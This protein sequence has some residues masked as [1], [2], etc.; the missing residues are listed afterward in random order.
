MGLG[1]LCKGEDFV[2]C[3]LQAGAVDL[4]RPFMILCFQLFKQRIIDP[5]VNVPLPIALLICRW[6]IADGPLI[7]I[8]HLDKRSWCLRVVL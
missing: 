3:E 6:N 8:P 7:H 5:E 1:Y 2:G 4:A